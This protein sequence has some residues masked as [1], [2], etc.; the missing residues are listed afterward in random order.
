MT[1]NDDT[2]DNKI[3]NT[4]GLD[5]K[6][7][8]TLINVS[9]KS[10]FRSYA[11][12][13]KSALSKILKKV[14]EGIKHGRYTYVSLPA[15]QPQGIELPKVKKK[16]TSKKKTAKKKTTSKKKKQSTVKS[17][18]RKTTK[19]EKSDYKGYSKTEIREGVRS[20]RAKA[21]RKKHGIVRPELGEDN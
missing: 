18:K 12:K 16:E 9:D 20:K 15:E 8:Q 13:S 6:E 11:R 1:L 7:K 17:P 4:K 5:D 3:K 10:W 14:K 19:K 2:I 21:Y